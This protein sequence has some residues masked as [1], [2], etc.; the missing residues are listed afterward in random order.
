MSTYEVL[1]LLMLSGTFLIALLAYVDSRNNKQVKYLAIKCKVF[2][3]RGSRQMSMQAW[4]LGS[5]LAEINKPTLYLA[6]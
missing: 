2:Y 3:S 6:V 5:L 4:P 1:T